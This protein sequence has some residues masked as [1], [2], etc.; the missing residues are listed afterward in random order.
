[1]SPRFLIQNI[2]A[3]EPEKKIPS[4]AAKATNL[5]A[6]VDFLSEIQRSA[7]SALRFIQGI[8][9]MAWKRCSRWSGS[10]T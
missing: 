10:L 8:V 7:Q 5:S 2:E 6:K 1:M 9:S 3:N 4:T